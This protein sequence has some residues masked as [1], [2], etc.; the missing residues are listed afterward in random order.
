MRLGNENIL[1]ESPGKAHGLVYLSHKEKNLD[2][3]KATV[4]RSLMSG[5]QYSSNYA[6]GTVNNGF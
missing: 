6:L 3:G 1:Q 5:L 4:K 2:C